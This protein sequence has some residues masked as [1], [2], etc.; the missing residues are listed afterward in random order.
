MIKTPPK[1]TLGQNFLHDP[2]IIQKI[3]DAANIGKD[4][5]V[6]EIGPGTG[7]LTDVLAKTC[8]KVIAIE[9]D[10]R[11]IDGLSERFKN[12]NVKIVE[13][14][15]LKID[16]KKYIEKDYKI[17]ANIPYY[18]T[19]HFIRLALEDWPRPDLIV[20]TIQ[21]EVA[22]RIIAQSPKTNLLAL[23]V[24][25]YADAKIVGRISAGSFYPKP[26]VD[27]AI[28]K[29]APKNKVPANSKFILEKISTLYS[30]KRGQLLSIIAKKYKVDR[31]ILGTVFR[32]SNIKPEQRP[33]T[34][35]LEDW[36]LLLSNLEKIL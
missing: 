21:K 30:Q 25:M 4:D 12:S 26:K 24:A 13:A 5:I 9:K 8:K 33:E 6:V 34:L 28:I 36:H 31:S 11:L 16:I 7:S 10:H 20:L 18:I 3:I 35:S 19:S 22:E 17:V 32:Q 27:S 1:K 2:K 29:M 23:S 14:D 15:I